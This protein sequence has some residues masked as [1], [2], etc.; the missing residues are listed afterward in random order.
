MTTRQETK[1]S[2]KLTNP[3]LQHRK[4]TAIKLLKDNITKKTELENGYGYEF[5]GTDETLDML[6]EFIK[7]ERQCCDFFNFNIAV[8]NNY[9]IILSITGNKGVKEFIASELEL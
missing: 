6:I 4:T 3:V 5:I 2:C 7:S 9:S 8:N 1:L